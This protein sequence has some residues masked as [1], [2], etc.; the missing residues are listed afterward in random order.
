M[1]YWFAPSATR[2][3]PALFSSFCL[4]PKDPYPGPLFRDLRFWLE[5]ADSV[6][7]I[8]AYDFDQF[9]VGFTSGA[10]EQVHGIHVTSNYFHLFGAPVLLGRSFGQADDLA[11]G[12]KVVVLSYRLW[13]RRFGR[14]ERIIGK[15]ISLDKE[16]YT[17]IGV[18]GKAFNSEP[19]GFV[20][21]VGETVNGVNVPQFGDGLGQLCSPVIDTE[22][23]GNRPSRSASSQLSYEICGDA[24][25]G[26]G[27]ISSK[28]QLLSG[29]SK[30]QSLAIYPIGAFVDISPEYPEAI[31]TFRSLRRVFFIPSS[32]DGGRSDRQLTLLWSWRF[33]LAVAR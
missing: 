16:S 12:P 11:N 24:V 3:L 21:D 9:K 5:R 1:L 10:P 27:L 25:P 20:I 15:T 31:G 19:E 22:R 2:I 8:A 29:R 4:H 28:L 7:D 30:E 6:E 33:Q 23:S 32:V 26:D 18:T 14:D 13:E 17:V